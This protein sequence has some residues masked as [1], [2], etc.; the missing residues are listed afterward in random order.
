[1]FGPLLYLLIKDLPT[2]VLMESTVRLLTN[3]CVFY[4]KIYSEETSQV[5]QKD[6]DALA[7]AGKVLVGGLPDKWHL[8]FRIRSWSVRSALNS[9][10]YNVIPI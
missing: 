4:L 3:D 9:L 6:F 2:Y 5:L 10:M 1:M 7:K 8:Y